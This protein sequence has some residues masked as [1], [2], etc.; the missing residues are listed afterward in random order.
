MPRFTKE[1]IQRLRRTKPDM[2][3]RF[4]AEDWALLIVWFIAASIGWWYMGHAS[5]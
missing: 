5:R 3:H 1:E 4:G 2:E